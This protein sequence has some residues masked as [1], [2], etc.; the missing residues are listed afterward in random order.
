MLARAVN[1]STLDFTSSNPPRL[2][3]VLYLYTVLYQSLGPSSLS[4]NSQTADDFST[5]DSRQGVDLKPTNDR[6]ER[7]KIGMRP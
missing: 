6:A 4:W 5:S 1:A 3:P 2:T 7:S